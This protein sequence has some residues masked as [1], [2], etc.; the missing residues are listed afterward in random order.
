MPRVV[1]NALTALQG[2][3]ARGELTGPA[4]VDTRADQL[5][6]LTV[7][8]NTAAR[9]AIEGDLLRNPYQAAHANVDTFEQR[10]NGNT[11]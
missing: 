2:T 3:L 8:I 1:R 5:L 7:G 10:P 4:Q 9:T 6:L 11:S